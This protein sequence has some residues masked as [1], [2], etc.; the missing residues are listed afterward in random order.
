MKNIRTFRL[1]PT[2]L[3]LLISLSGILSSRAGILEQLFYDEIPGVDVQDLKDDPWYPDSFTFIQA[4]DPDL[5]FV[6]NLRTENQGSEFGSLIKGYILAPATGTFTIFIASDNGSEISLSSNTDPANLALVAFESGCCQRLFGG[7][8]LDERSGDVEWEAGGIYYFEAIYKEG[9]GNDWLEVG[10]LRPDGTKE[11][12]PSAFLLP[13]TKDGDEVT[14]PPSFD[15]EPDSIDTE[16]GGS[17]EFVAHVTGL[18]PMTFQWKKDGVNIDGAIFPNYVNETITSS[19]DAAVYT[20]DVSN[21]VGSISSEDAI[22]FVTPDTDPPELRLADTRGNPN[23]LTIFF[24]EAVTEASATNLGNYSIDNGSITITAAVLSGKRVVN[25]VGEP[26]DLRVTL[27]VGGAGWQEGSTYSVTVSGVTDKAE[28]PNSMLSTTQEFFY[29]PGTLT[30]WDFN[31]GLPEGSE[32]AGVSEYSEDE[33]VDGS[34]ALVLTRNLGGQLGGW[35][36]GP[37]GTVGRF[38]LDFDIYM[39][40]G[41]ATQAD[42]V[43]M[44]ISDDLEPVTA[45]G[46]GGRGLGLRVNFDNWSNNDG[47][48]SIEIEYGGERIATVP[49]GTQAQSTLDTDGW[50]PVHIEVTTGGD[51]TVIYN[52][53]IIHE[54]VNIPGWGAI[55]DARMAFGARTGGANA[56]QWID[57]I[58]FTLGGGKVGPLTI[59]SQSSGATVKENDAFTLE[60]AAEG[61]EPKSYQWFLDGV[62]IAWA[63]RKN[64]SVAQAT[65]DTQGTYTAVVQNEFSKVETDPIV[66]AIPTDIDAPAIVDITGS[67]T[68]VTATISFDELV[69]QATAEETANYS[70]VDVASG[71][72][73]AVLGATLLGDGLKVRLSTAKHTSGQTYQVTV[74]RVADVSANANQTQNAQ[75]SFTAFMSGGADITGFWDFNDGLPEGSEVAGNAEHSV[76]EGVDGSGALVITRALGGQKGGW[77]SDTIGTVDNISIDFDILMDGGTA[78]QADGISMAISDDL[79][80]VTAFGEGGRGLG[81]RVNF[82]NWDNNDGAPS[83]EIEYGGERIASVPMG[84]QA[85]STLDT[86]GWWPVHIEV[87]TDGDV[88]VIYNGETIH[89][90]VNVP[91]FSPIENAR[92]AFGGRTGGANANQWIDNF[93]YTIKSFTPDSETLE[94]DFNDGLPE[95]SEVAGVSEYSEDEG[96]DG[97]GALVITRA[98]GGQLG[99]W[100][101]AEVGTIDNFVIDFDIYMA[102]G[103]PTQADGISLS[104]AGDLEPVRAFS[105]AGYGSGLRVNFDNWDNNDGAPSIEIEYG[106]EQIASVPMGTQTESTLDTDGWWPVHIELTSDGDLTLT[107]NGELIHDSVNISEFAAIENARIAFGGRT[108]GANANQWIDNFRMT[109]QNFSKPPSPPADADPTI[110]VSADADGN[111]VVTFTGVL[112]SAPDVTGPWTDAATEDQSPL[113]LTPDQARLF[114][115]TRRP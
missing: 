88:T 11:V 98:L 81:L 67:G 78:T 96:V 86:D 66:I 44:A 20:V 8:R 89:D 70:I 75:G 111:V 69:S 109:R 71:E 62:P 65:L 90:Q 105:E 52:D 16:E 51:V 101:S 46:E 33:G 103:T 24:N 27:T 77:L 74:N 19:D 35:L 6:T 76:T 13:A 45:F 60:V 48:P 72:S 21:S 84:T 50:W 64:I 3:V 2:I 102:D 108:G 7:A 61:S 68:F 106:G 63:T 10:W 99:G 55:E 92:I 113:T 85:D 12:I 49:M 36:S 28:N 112:Q 29:G 59:T 37:M 5:G 79:E 17:A 39:D 4:F 26:G 110:S 32:V 31:D 53:E 42:G 93:R 82:D 87:T 56:N 22:L 107:Y 94:W 47:A 95:G 114:G 34:G 41:T 43:S 83:I 18:Q 30:E 15:V 57:N 9:D 1:K 58:S 104:I 100:L 80:P 25:G 115:R 40:D 73:L 23:G 54:N 97:S 91:D 14:G 38:I